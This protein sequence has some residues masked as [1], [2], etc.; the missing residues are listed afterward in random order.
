M[1]SYIV[2]TH[3]VTGSGKGKAGWFK[4]TAANISY[5]HPYHVD[6]EHALNIDFVNDAVGLDAR[7][8]V[9]LSL[10]SAKQLA[11]AL[12]SACERAEEYEDSLNRRKPPA[13]TAIHSNHS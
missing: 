10:E 5:D 4:V 11:A 3:P 9:E 2:E 13:S 7:V 6:L 1:C 12:L 8:A